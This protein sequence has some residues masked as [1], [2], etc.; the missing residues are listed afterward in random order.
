MTGLEPVGGGALN[1]SRAAVY[2]D[3]ARIPDNA[4]NLP[5]DEPVVPCGPVGHFSTLPLKACLPGLSRA[6]IPA[7]VSRPGGTTRPWRLPRWR[8]AWRSLPAR[9]R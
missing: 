9:P 6:G 3:D 2:M 8:G 5:V 4:G 1:P 7:E